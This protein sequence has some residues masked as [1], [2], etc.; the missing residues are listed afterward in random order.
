M[1]SNDELITAY[2]DGHEAGKKEV[3]TFPNKAAFERVCKELEE[4]PGQSQLTFAHVGDVF[5]TAFWIELVYALMD[6]QSA[7]LAIQGAI[8]RLSK[9][10][11]AEKADGDS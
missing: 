5:G 8:R 4:G 6:A 9:G 11:K 2:K 7:A 10:E 3:G 1:T